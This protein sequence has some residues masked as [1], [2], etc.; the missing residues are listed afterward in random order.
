MLALAMSVAIASAPPSPGNPWTA[1]SAYYLSENELVS[2]RD[3]ALRGDRNSAIRLSKYYRFYLSD[4]QA[5]LFWTR[6]AAELGD[7]DAVE[8][9]S[10]LYAWRTEQTD[11]Q[12]A[13]WDQRSRELHC[14]R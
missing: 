13:Y 6:L 2:N 1:S 5:R 11:G 7:C 12:N 8:W 10:E 14:S 9:V 4:Q 3:K